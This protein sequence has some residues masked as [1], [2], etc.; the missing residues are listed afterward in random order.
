MF[1]EKQK[2]AAALK[3]ALQSLANGI[4]IDAIYSQTLTAFNQVLSAKDYEGLLALY[5]RKSLSAQASGAL[6]LANGELPELV[7]RLAKGD[8]RD[9]VS[10]ALRKYFGS[11]AVHIA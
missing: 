5:N 2:G 4:D 9:E 6:G 10:D 11:F 1:N 3:A 8:S 7:V